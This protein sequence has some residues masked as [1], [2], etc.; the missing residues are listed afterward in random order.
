VRENAHL[1]ISVSNRE[2]S[3]ANVLSRAGFHDGAALHA[4]RAASSALVAIFAH[5][6]SAP[7][8]DRCED[9]C[10]ALAA[11]DMAATREVLGAART[12]DAGV[13]T[14]DLRRPDHAPAEP[15][16][17]RAGT[18]CLDAMKQIRAFVNTALSGY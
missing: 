16:D 12:L 15:C 2:Q 7:A 9:L 10:Q 3:M 1:W 8:S 18:E 17:A 11:H 14:P 4:H 5:L 6:G 13:A